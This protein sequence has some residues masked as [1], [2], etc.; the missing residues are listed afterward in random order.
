MV[1]DHYMTGLHSISVDKLITQHWYRRCYIYL[2]NAQG[3]KQL[4]LAPAGLTQL[5][6]STSWQVLSLLCVHL[7]LHAFV[8]LCW[9]Q[10]PGDEA[11]RCTTDHANTPQY[12]DT[13]RMLMDS[14][15]YENLLPGNGTGSTPIADAIWN[16]FS[17]DG[18]D[19]TRTLRPTY[20]SLLS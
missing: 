4:R 6:V 16:D 17:F 3:D 7:S 1:V 11:D 19:V 8:G 12:P 18:N 15:S 9:A 13:I 2:S 10:A 14:Y 5:L 20:V